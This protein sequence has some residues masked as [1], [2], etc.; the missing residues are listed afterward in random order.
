MTANATPK[1]T[2]AVKLRNGRRM[3][4]AEWDDLVGSTDV[5]LHG[6]PEAF[7]DHAT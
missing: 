1:L 4:H 7:D 3:G 6:Q 5:L 2:R